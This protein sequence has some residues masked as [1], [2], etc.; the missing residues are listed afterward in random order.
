MKLVVTQSFAGYQVGDSIS[1]P[2]K[3]EEVLASHPGSVVRSTQDPEPEVLA[4]PLVADAASVSRA[5]R[6]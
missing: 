6:R 4:R 1:D 2:D 5:T 3:M